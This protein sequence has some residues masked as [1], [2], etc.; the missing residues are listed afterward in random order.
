MQIIGIG[1]DLAWAVREPPLLHEITAYFRHPE[2]QPGWGGPRTTWVGRAEGR[3]PKI[4]LG[5]EGLIP[6]HHN[7]CRCGN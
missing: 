7:Y 2:N 6:V 5:G 4:N 3:G 1:S